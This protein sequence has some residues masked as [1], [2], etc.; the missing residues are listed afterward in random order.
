MDARFPPR[1]VAKGRIWGV[2]KLTVSYQSPKLQNGRSPHGQLQPFF[3]VRS[4]A[5][6]LR[7]S[8]RSAGASA[9]RRS[10]DVGALGEGEPIV[11]IDAQ[12]ANRAFDLGVAK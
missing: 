7:K 4:A 1:S 10:L 3:Q 9:R 2:T 6:M 5:G 11:D 12:V 8:R